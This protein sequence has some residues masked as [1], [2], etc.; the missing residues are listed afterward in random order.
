MRFSR[1]QEKSRRIKRFRLMPLHVLDDVLI[2]VIYFTS[3]AT[4]YHVYLYSGLAKAA[5][6]AREEIARE[7]I[8]EKE[9]GRER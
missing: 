4:C 6:D 7:H 8:D 3:E 2:A 9:R 5:R 1:S